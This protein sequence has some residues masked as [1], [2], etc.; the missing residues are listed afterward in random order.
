[1]NGTSLVRSLTLIKYRAV[2][3]PDSTQNFNLFRLINIVYFRWDN[4]YHI[5]DKLF[6]LQYLKH[7]KK[8]KLYRR[9][10]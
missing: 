5:N 10:V 7:R 4:Y 6:Y 3:F 8:N 2:R 1:M 9:E